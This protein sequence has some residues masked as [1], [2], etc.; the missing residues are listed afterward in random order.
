MKKTQSFYAELTLTSD[1]WTG[2]RETSNV[3]SLK[4]HPQTEALA[5]SWWIEC[6]EAWID[7]L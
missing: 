4:V 1:D 7:H 3:L 6:D 5:A 2:Q